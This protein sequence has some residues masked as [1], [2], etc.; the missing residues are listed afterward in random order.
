MALIASPS[1]A[2][3]ITRPLVPSTDGAVDP[4]VAGDS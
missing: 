4:P 2:E 3:P 1:T